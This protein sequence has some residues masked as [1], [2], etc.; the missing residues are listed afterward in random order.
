MRVLDLIRARWILF[1]ENLCP[2]HFLRNNEAHI[3]GPGPMKYGC[4]E[5]V[6]RE[7][8]EEDARRDKKRSRRCERRVWAE[9]V[10]RG[11]NRIPNATSKK[12]ADELST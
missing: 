3:V 9:K 7:V 2:K 1:R 10:W 6:K 5:C 4:W 11:R 8:A 12:A